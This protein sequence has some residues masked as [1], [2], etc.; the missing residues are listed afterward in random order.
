MVLSPRW[1]R[2]LTCVLAM[3]L[4]ASCG[5]P[6]SGPDRDEVVA[7]PEEDIGLDFNVIP[8]TPDVARM[9]RVDERSGF[10][11]SLINTPEEPT[12]LIA[13][14]DVMS[15]TVWENID[16]GL[17][18]PQGIGAS[19][20]PNS[21][22][23]ERGM[24]FVP[25]VGLIKAAG[26]TLNTVR[27]SIQTA[28]AQRTL[29]PQVD[30]YPIEKGGRLVSV[31]GSVNAPGLYPIEKPTRTL[32]PMLA[33]AGGVNDDPKTIR[34]K[35]RRGRLLGEISLQDLYDD[36]MNNIPVR[37]GDALIAERDRRIFTALG[38]VSGPQAVPFPT[39]DVSV[40]R[41]LGLVGGLVDSRADPT[42]VFIFREE[43]PEIANRLMPGQE[44]TETTKVA[45]IFDLTQPGALFLAGDFMMRNDDTLY[46]TTAPFVRW[47]KIMQAISPLVA[48]GGSARALGGF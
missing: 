34:I 43:P 41:A 9:T 36:P 35:L 27:E 24:V 30:I 20:L 12:Q 33:R 10:E 32:L 31:Q 3:S 42:G 29:N 15:I 38:A 22:V 25:Y 4:V 1:M 6:R 28:L 21:I 17:L 48:F 40:I 18:N 14:G 13:E 47:L 5:L 2:T 8:V 19:Q 26:R 46:V 37:S 16:E 45:Y 23:D 39:R 7:L 44:F 11:V